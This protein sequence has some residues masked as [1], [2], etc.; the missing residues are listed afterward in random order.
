VYGLAGDYLPGTV[1]A[2]AMRRGEPVLTM[3]LDDGRRV[4]VDSR[5]FGGLDHAYAL[6]INKSHTRILAFGKDELG[7]GHSLLPQGLAVRVKISEGKICGFE[8]SQVEMQL[9]QGA[10]IER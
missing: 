2:V 4:D 10:R 3:T 9:P 1:T 8:Q 6:T 7:K 5:H